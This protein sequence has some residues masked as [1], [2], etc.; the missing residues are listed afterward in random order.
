MIRTP[1]SFQSLSF[2]Y[3]PQT[4]HIKLMRQDVKAIYRKC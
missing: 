2:G 1:P 3:L 4:A